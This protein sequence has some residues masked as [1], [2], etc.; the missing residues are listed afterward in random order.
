MLIYTRIV[1]TYRELF[2]V[3]YQ[4]AKEDCRT[5]VFLN[6]VSCEMKFQIVKT[7]TVK[8]LHGSSFINLNSQCHSSYC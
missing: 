5:F 6:S 8:Q 2:C 3:Q 4:S 1:N 7:K